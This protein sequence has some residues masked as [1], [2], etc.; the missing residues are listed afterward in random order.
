M[1]TIQ[2][3]SIENSAQ[4]LNAFPVEGSIS[5]LLSERI[6]LDSASKFIYLLLSTPNSPNLGSLT[7]DVLSE[8][9][10]DVFEEIEC[11]YSQ[12]QA[13]DN[14]RVLV[15]PVDPLLPGRQYH[16][17]V[18]KELPPLYWQ[19]NKLSRLGNSTISFVPDKGFVS[20]VDTTYRLE[21]GRNSVLAGG[22]HI[23]T[24]DLIRGTQ[25]I[26]DNKALDITK[27]GIKVDGGIIQPGPSIPF[28]ATED[29]S[30]FLEAFS[31]LGT[32]VTQTIN[33]FAPSV[34]Y[35]GT[36]ERSQRLRHEDILKFYERTGM[37][38]RT[39][40]QMT[41]LSGS[42]VLDKKL[43][44]EFEYPNRIHLDLGVRI[45]PT[46]LTNASFNI[47]FGYAFGNYM[48]PKLGL[49]DTTKQYAFRWSLHDDQI[50]SIEVLNAA[51]IPNTN[52]PHIGLIVLEGYGD[53]ST[54]GTIT[55][56]GFSQG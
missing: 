32:T 16:L 30:L 2:V 55:L 42:V 20:G 5:I 49:F 35:E 14:Y 50:I 41:A 6:D 22:Q 1:K 46:S 19:I 36:E 52:D 43:K 23:L 54:S 10:Q 13:V 38:A 40:E 45:D 26:G 21:V 11:E 44:V 31:R 29:F 17:V 12:V 56:S 47:K 34:K 25:I 7:P 24:Y 27:G 39:K 37:A 51:D 8:T 3:V 4:E 33:T 28:I 9:Y 53:G 15:T 18:S 48:L